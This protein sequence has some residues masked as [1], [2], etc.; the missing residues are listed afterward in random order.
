MIYLDLL[1]GFLQVGFFSFG[2][3]YAAI[4]LIRDIVLAYGW[5][6]DEL[7]T[8][9]IAVSESTPGPI[10]VNM[11]T[12]VGSVKGGILGAMIATAAVVLPAFVIILLIMILLKKLLQN[13]FVRAALSGLKPCI[14]G[15]ILATGILMIIRT[16]GIWPAGETDVTTICLTFVMAIIYFGSRKILK[17]GIRPIMLICLSAIAGLIIY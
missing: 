1:L 9:M 11:A 17:K 3:G 6:D 4:P 12:Y 15:I 16:C 10:M 14:I 2:G 13:K 7:L 5:L 8:N